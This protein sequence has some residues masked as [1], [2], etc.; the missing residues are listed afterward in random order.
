MAAEARQMERDKI[1][2]VTAHPASASSMLRWVGR[3]KGPQG[4]PYEGGSFTIDIDIPEGYP[5]KPPK[6]RFRTPI[7]HPNITGMTNSC[8][9]PEVFKKKARQW[10]VDHAYHRRRIVKPRHEDNNAY[11]Q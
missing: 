2:G 1:D 7:W 8:L 11:L 10:T 6:M 9:F 5:F 4:T 3:I